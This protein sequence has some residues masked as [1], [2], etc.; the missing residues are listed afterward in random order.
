MCGKDDRMILKGR[1]K[2]NDVARVDRLGIQ[3][4]GKSKKERKSFVMPSLMAWEIQRRSGETWCLMIVVTF[5]FI[6]F[7][8]TLE[9]NK[10]KIR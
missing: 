3:R 2:E 8:R 6:L 7:D 4:S 5:P 1:R 9:S 10:K